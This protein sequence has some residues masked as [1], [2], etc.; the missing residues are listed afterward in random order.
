[1]WQ[2]LKSALPSN[3]QCWS[4]LN[5]MWVK[6][7]KISLIYMPQ[8]QI[9]FSLLSYTLDDYVWAKFTHKLITARNVLYAA[10]WFSHI[11]G[12]VVR[13]CNVMITGAFFIWQGTSPL[14][15]SKEPADP[16]ISKNQNERRLL[17]LFSQN[18]K[19]ELWTMCDFPYK[20]YFYRISEIR[21]SV[22]GLACFILLIY[23]I[24]V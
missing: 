1:M 10:R 12:I 6:S 7:R 2:M 21:N 17:S 11:G 23:K 22:S 19:R 3:L 20:H 4:C 15:I 14:E 13:K 9:D 5:L 8:S 18:L 24:R 16:S